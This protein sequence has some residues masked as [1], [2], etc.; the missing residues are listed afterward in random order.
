MPAERIHL[1]P[2]GDL[3]IKVRPDKDPLEYV[4]SKR[5]MCFASP[6]WRAMLTGQFSESTASEV[7]FPED[8][9]DALLIV[10]RIA[11][12]Q[13]ALLPRSMSFLMV[14]KL[15]VLCDK[16]DTV[17]LVKPFLSMWVDPHKENLLTVNY[18]EWFFVAWVF[19]YEEEFNQLLHHSV[20]RVGRDLFA[21][22]LFL[23]S[24]P[25]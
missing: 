12:L 7:P 5:T 23:N 6:A 16:Y 2:D 10:L 3:T 21:R 20:V 13:F 4:V 11:H 22:G 8:D 24:R 15:A 14:V 1:D 9:P 18:Q 17:A 25:L 19:G